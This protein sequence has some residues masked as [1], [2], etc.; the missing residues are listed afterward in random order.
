MRREARLAVA[1][2][3]LLAAAATAALVAFAQASCA[4]DL[5]AQP[6]A[7]AGLNRAVVV[8][9]VGLIA[10]LTATPFAFLAE[11]AVRRRIVY[12][13]SWG[14]A[15][16]RGLLAGLVVAALAGL[17]VGG[18]LGVPAAIFVLVM[19]ALAEWFAVRRFDLP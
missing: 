4:A 2:F 9:L 18:A 13:G 3:V 6:C 12:R 14:R 8:S 11:F 5:P 16:R 7:Q 19:A 10:F 1:G 17:R 15:L